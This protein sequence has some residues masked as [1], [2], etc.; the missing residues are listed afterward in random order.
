[1]EPRTEA[2]ASPTDEA[3]WRAAAKGD[4][5]AF[6]TIFDRHGDRVFRHAWRMMQHRQDS[7]D[8]TAA[9]FAELWRKRTRVRFVDGS[10]LP[11][12][13]ATTTNVARNAQRSLRRN[14]RLLAHI[15]RPEH[16]PDAAD[17][18]EDRIHGIE[19][20]SAVGRA[21]AELKEPDAQLITLVMLEEVPLADAARAIGVGYGA[22]KVRMHR[23]RAR[24]REQLALLGVHDATTE[25]VRS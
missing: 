3:I 22:A 9:A 10:V 11:W 17:Q 12:L 7:E 14:R 20:R 19:A 16:A 4:G 25:E 2:S 24:L 15:P 5:V 23:A 8:V 13:L 6:A 18:A 21:L 1:M